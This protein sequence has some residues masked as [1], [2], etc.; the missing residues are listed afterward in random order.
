MENILDKNLRI[1]FLVESPEKSKTITK[2]FRDAGY[3]NIIVQATVGHFTKIADGDGYFNTG[4]FPDDQF[5]INYI[6][7]PNKKEV[8]KKL[9]EQVKAANLVMLASDDDREGEAIAWAC[10]K[11]LNIP[12]S[13]YKRVKYNA[14]N[15]KAIFDAINNAG[16]LDSNLVDAAHARSVLDKSL[17]YRLSGVTRDQIACKSVGRC[18]S[19]AVKLIVDREKEIIDFKPEKYIDLFLKF[20]KNKIEF[21]AKYIGTDKKPVKHLKTNEE[22]DA[23][24]DD[25]KGN[26]FIISSIEHKD[27]AENPKPPF[28]TATFQ[29]ECANKLN[30][31][32]KQSADCAQKLFD[33][34]KI[35]YHR[36]DS[37]V[38]SDEFATELKLFVKAHFDNKYV[39][40]KVVAGK[41]DE[42]AQEA[43]EAIHCLDLSLTPELYAKESP[44]DLLTKVYRIIYNRTIA[45]ALN[46]AI[47]AQTTYTISNKEHKFVMN[48]NELR[49][50]GYR[51]VYSY[52][53]DSDEKENIIKETFD[54]KEKLQKCTF[55]AVPGETKPK[56]RYKEA[57]FIKELKDL[58]I[59]RPSTYA[60]IVETVKSE[61]RGYCVVEDK[62]LKPTEKGFTLVN[63]LDQ[64]F[65]DLI[66]IG[67]TRDMETSLDLI[68]QGKLNYFD[69][70]KEFFKHLEDSVSK[71]DG[72]S[73]LCPNCGKPLRLRKGPYG[74]FLGCT[75]YPACKYLMPINKKVDN[76]K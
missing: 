29:Q 21:K 72:G 6:V 27:R 46:P 57:S 40:G 35:S 56:S 16:D 3:N 7:D 20:I 1:L 51:C 47:I 14:I 13:K 31:T 19:P 58:G 62:C 9:K 5:R 28:S 67:Y 65:S 36:T 53:D 54:E 52:K 15:K 61:S 24:Y 42:N 70:L 12:K 38:F 48:S 39:S 44:S 50:D 64:N 49:F 66:N 22:I 75:G 60:T 25:C 8:V 59:G 32:V 45:T 26:D 18:Q 33:A 23:I 10:I 63:F 37:E 4:I 11:F 71:V 30:L 17:G 43:H 55:D 69:F 2:I 74:A 73:Q 34:G 76:K 41:N 68:A